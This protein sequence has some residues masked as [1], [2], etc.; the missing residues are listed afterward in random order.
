M[1]VYDVYDRGG[2]L[3]FASVAPSAEA[4]AMRF[5]F[6]WPVGGLPRRFGFRRAMW[7]KFL[8]ALAGRTTVARAA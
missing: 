1:F 4:T 5:G 2:P 6:R 3:V 7:A 8:V